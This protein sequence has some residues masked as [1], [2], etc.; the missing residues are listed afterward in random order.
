MT[1]VMKTKIL[2]L[3]CFILLGGIMFSCSKDDN[4][5]NSIDPANIPADV[6]KAFN[7]VYP[8]T[9]A[10]WST[11]DSFY[12]AE[13]GND[14]NEIDVWFTSSGTI[15]LTVKEI[16]SSQLPQAIQT[17][18]QGT[19]YA[20]WNYDDVKLIQ[21]KGFDDLYK[22]EMDDPKTESDVTLYYTASGVLVKEVPDIDNSP[23]TPAV[24]PQNIIDQ[25]DQ[26]FPAKQYKIVDYD[27]E[28]STRTY[29]VDI[30]E[31]N[32]AVEV[33]FDNSQIL[34]YWQWETTF[35]KVAPNVQAAFQNL[36]YTEKQIDD[37][38]Y[39][40]TPNASPR[41]NVTSYVF[42]LE[43]NGIDKT[44]ILNENGTVIS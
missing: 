4:N 35:A 22:V 32:I 5:D 24:V 30:I 36:G 28:S 6:M 31:A 23:I 34:T 25:L 11:N 10:K 40:Q 29:E 21:R 7:Q 14:N 19:K 42:E 33:I 43:I 17:A 3:L 37:I 41:E 12:V 44:V 27:Y 13:F 20:A 1:L 18:V 38:Y 16:P 26:Y 8:N 15:M 9:N 39:R 2:T